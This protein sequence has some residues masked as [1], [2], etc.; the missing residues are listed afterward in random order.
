VDHC[1]TEV[2]RARESTLVPRN[3]V[4]PGAVVLEHMSMIDR[5]IVEPLSRIV[6]GVSATPHDLFNQAIGLGDSGA[7][8]ID[9]LRLHATP[10]GAQPVRIV[11]RERPDR[12]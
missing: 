1:L 10:C 2:L 8:L 6:R 11:V 4:T 7:R 9:K 5:E 12:K 3:D